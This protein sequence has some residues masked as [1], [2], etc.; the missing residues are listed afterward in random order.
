VTGVAADPPV[1]PTNLG[2]QAVSPTSINLAWTDASANELGFEVERRTGEGAWAWLATLGANATTY[3][4]TRLT[5]GI[6]YG[7]RVRAYNTAGASP[8]SNEVSATYQL[9]V[10]ATAGIGGT[11]SCN[12]ATVNYNDSSTCTASPDTGYAF[13]AWTGACAGQGAACSLT[14]I[15]ADKVSAAS[16]ALKTYDVTATAG[17]NG[18]ISPASQAVAHGATTTFT[19]TPTT[20]YTASVSGCGGSLSGSTYTTGAITA[21]CV[22]SASFTLNSY[23]VTASADANGTISPAS[24]TVAHGATTTF[25]VTPETGYSAT[26][27]GCGGSLSGTTYTTG[28]ITAACAVSASFTLNSYTVTAT[29]G[30][31]APSARPRA[32]SPMAP[33]QPLP[34]PR[35]RATAPASPVAVAPSRA[36]PTPPTP[37]PPPARSPPA[38][39]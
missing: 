26:V 20:D 23:T 12:P 7:Y 8:Y 25:A 21:A 29:A 28:P 34:S 31:M 2:A 3:V 19:V 18:S 35:R 6:T 24:Q 11:A 32:V 17:A 10:T 5:Q 13:V 9:A 4:D 38:L 22:V 16:F 14:G 30:P 1:T 33:R 37:S 39:A 36:P 27:S 15:Q